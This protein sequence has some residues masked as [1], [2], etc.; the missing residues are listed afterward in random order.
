M[1]KKLW[2]TPL[3]LK[4][5]VQMPV[6]DGEAA[7]RSYPIPVSAVPLTST[8][9][10]KVSL[11]WSAS[12]TLS[13]RSEENTRSKEENKVFIVSRGVNRYVIP[14]EDLGMLLWET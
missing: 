1:L 8:V 11:S 9:E 14:L 3:S 5:A 7:I 12:V 4:Y 10:G 2:A 13:S 6:L